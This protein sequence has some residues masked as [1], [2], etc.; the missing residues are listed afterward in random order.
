MPPPPPFVGSMGHIAAEGNWITT[1]TLVNKGGVPSQAQLNFFGDAADPSGN[2]PLTL[3]LVFSQRFP[4]GSV[5]ASFYAQTLAAN[6]SLI[7]TT[8]GRRLPKIRR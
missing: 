4:P 6:A 1:F 3:P 2:G 8:G 7:I 5:L